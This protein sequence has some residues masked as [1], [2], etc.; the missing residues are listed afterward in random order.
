MFYSNDNTTEYI[1]T[2][3]ALYLS[4]YLTY[5][6]TQ[7][8]LNKIGDQKIKSIMRIHSIIFF[9]AIPV[10]IIIFFLKADVN[11]DIQRNNTDNFTEDINLQ[12]YNILTQQY[13][14]LQKQYNNLLT[15]IASQNSAY[16]N[17]NNAVN[18]NINTLIGILN[19]NYNNLINKIQN[20]QQLQNN[21]QSIIDAIQNLENN[22]NSINTLIQSMPNNNNGTSQL[23]FIYTYKQI[24]NCIK[25]IYRITPVNYTSGIAANNNIDTLTY[26]TYEFDGSISQINGLFIDNNT[27]IDFTNPVSLLYS[28]EC[29]NFLI[30]QPL[31][32][33]NSIITETYTF[34][35]NNYSLNIYAN[36]FTINGNEYTITYDALNQ[37]FNIDESVYIFK[38]FIFNNNTI[39]K[40]D[41]DGY[42]YE[43]TNNS[44]NRITQEISNIFTYELTQLPTNTNAF[45][46]AFT[47]KANGTT[48]IKYINNNSF[49]TYNIFNTSNASIPSLTNIDISVIGD[50]NQD[51]QYMCMFW[52]EGPFNLI[53]ICNNTLSKFMIQQYNNQNLNPVFSYNN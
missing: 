21:T 22:A 7:F 48:N 5:L 24:L 47:I 3:G 35:Y 50:T 26:K 8:I 19:Q 25:N 11:I 13:N 4:Y 28:K 17:A 14:T 12:T 16:S 1:Q 36:K 2:L 32:N 38:D 46:A 45:T 30:K 42:I 43:I 37:L 31:I 53:M 27:K 15:N 39:I 29:N 44:I 40:H 9:V 51:C 18:N 34:P 6:F 41:I 52:Q 20:T 23:E 49:Q 10:M 33:N